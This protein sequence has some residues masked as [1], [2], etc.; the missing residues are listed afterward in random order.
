MSRTRG[1]GDPLMLTGRKYRL[2]LTPDQAE[3]AERI[4]G[5]CRSVWNTGL[6][7]R[8]AYRLHGAFIGYHEQARQLVDAKT[9]F[10]WLA[11]VPGHCLQ[12]TLIDLDRA[13]AKHGTWRVRWKTKIKNS[14]AFRFPKAGKSRSNA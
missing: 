10:P 12:Q 1:T 8:R 5:A 6:E 7:Q 4:G 2:D 3:F 9:E 14:P 11:E 13:C